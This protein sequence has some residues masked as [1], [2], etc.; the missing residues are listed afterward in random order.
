MTKIN[1]NQTKMVKN[2]QNKQK[3]TNYHKKYGDFYNSK[4]WKY[5]R[6]YK[7]VQAKGLCEKCK[8]KG[9]IRQGREVHHIIPIEQDWGKRLD[10]DNL[11]LLCP[12][13]HQE[14]HNRDSQ[15]QKFLREWDS[16]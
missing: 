12:S 2:K 4:E 6:A 5:L 13:C 11:I 10:Y 3:S 15:L 14:A 7:F 9:I 1:Q 8:E 16:I